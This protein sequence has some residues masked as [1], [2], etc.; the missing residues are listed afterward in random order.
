M[1]SYESATYTIGAVV[2]G[3]CLDRLGSLEIAVADVLRFWAST[4]SVPILILY[5]PH[6]SVA[7]VVCMSVRHIVHVCY[8]DMLMLRRLWHTEQLTKTAERKEF[9]LRLTEAAFRSTQQTTALDRLQEE[10]NI[11]LP[12]SAQNADVG[13][14]SSAVGSARG[15]RG[16][17]EEDSAARRSR[18]EDWASTT[19]IADP[20]RTLMFDAENGDDAG[21][22]TP[23]A[24]GAA[25]ADE[26][27]AN[28]NVG[29]GTAGDVRKAK[30]HQQMDQVS[31]SES[32][33][34]HCVTTG[35]SRSRFT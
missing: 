7:S 12:F 4:T 34:P 21:A 35:C 10:T 27:T 19:D 3:V 5:M 11:R 15:N 1:C 28:G 17:V 2:D 33:C 18:V 23:T 31:R 25:G 6:S 29:D 9:A 14:G 22:R 30:S 13:A 8:D 24:T 20:A 16:D 32:C 26:A